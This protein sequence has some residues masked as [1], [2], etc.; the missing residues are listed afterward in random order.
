MTLLR[1]KPFQHW[2][3]ISYLNI[4]IF[5]KSIIDCWSFSIELSPNSPTL[6]LFSP[7]H[8]QLPNL[9]T[10][11]MLEQCLE[12]IKWTKLSVMFPVWFFIVLILLICYLLFI[13]RPSEDSLVMIYKSKWEKLQFW[14]RNNLSKQ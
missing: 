9:F 1:H 3:N 5:Y 10:F 4:D 6:S 12:F 11:K 14:F 13:T 7:F 2:I 8:R